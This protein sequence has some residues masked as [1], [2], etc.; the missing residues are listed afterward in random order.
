[1]CA[2]SGGEIGVRV[3]EAMQRI[4]PVPTQVAVA[5][6]AEMTADAMSRALRGER[7]FSSIELARIADFLRTDIHWLITGEPDPLAARFVARHTYDHQSREYDVAGRSG[8]AEILGGVHLAY[9]Q[10]QP[11]LDQRRV[12]LPNTPEAIRSLLDEGFV[13]AF[14]DWVEQCLG[15]DVVRIPGL[16]TDYSF[17]I[18]GRPVVL[19]AAQTYWFRSNF[20]LAHEL[21]HLA[22][23][24]PECVEG[25]GGEHER[26]ANAFAAQLLLPESV[27]RRIPWAE[28]TEE[29]VASFLW[30]A[31]VSTESL[32]IRLSS[33]GLPMPGSLAD[34]PQSKTLSLLRRNQSAIPHE[35]LPNTSL[36][37]FDPI[38]T[39][40]QQAA[41]RRI[42]E[43]L[44]SALVRGVT[45]GNL[46]TGTLSWLL[47]LPIE[48]DS[49]EGPDPEPST[50]DLIEELG[51]RAL[52]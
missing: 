35:P 44:A 25:A 39:R 2:M 48:D 30:H 17:I 29:E 41:E 10:A 36:V 13:R 49:L 9:R 3:R 52:S 8:D 33:L 4:T 1:M 11:W 22:L 16:S 18:N 46:N 26:V 20:S 34:N 15:V 7:G 23:G 5:E 45:E 31:G 12:E 32:K 50:D 27:V 47:G 38:S 21:A 28:Q 43:A 24:H 37:E 40:I 51:I 19:L 14:A 6:H 42:P